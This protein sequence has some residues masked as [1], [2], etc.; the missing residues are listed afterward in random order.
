MKDLIKSKKRVKELG[1]VF[2]PKELIRKMLDKLP[3]ASWLPEKTFLEPSCGTG[4]FIVEIVQ[5]KMEKGS[6][7][8]QALST[9]YG[10]D[11]M[12]D[13]VKEC[14]LRLQRIMLPLLGEEEFLEA[15]KIISNNIIVGNTL[16]QDL[17][18]Q[19]K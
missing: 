13:N 17:E 18:A 6:T 3:E 19:M 8:L 10:V 16:V 7:P 2:T 11:I 1:E 14:Q 15:C 4:N 5:V 9:T 12:P